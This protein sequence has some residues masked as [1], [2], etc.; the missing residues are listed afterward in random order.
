M[1]LKTR[2]S[3]EIMYRVIHSKD[4]QQNILFTILSKLKKLSN[5]FAGN[6]LRFLKQYAEYSWDC[7]FV[8]YLKTT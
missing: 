5:H 6:C 1:I 2:K 7:K 3:L 4:P 8:C